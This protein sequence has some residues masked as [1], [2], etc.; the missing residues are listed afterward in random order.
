M[1]ALLIDLND[2][3]EKYG[4]RKANDIGD[5]DEFGCPLGRVA[6]REQKL[7]DL[8]RK[9]TGSKK[10]ASKKRGEPEAKS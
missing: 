5:G 7:N 9:K 4:N 2:P 10:A 3:G 6:L 1:F 8:D